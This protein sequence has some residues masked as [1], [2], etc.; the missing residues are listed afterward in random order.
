MGGHVPLSTPPG[1][2]PVLTVMPNGQ[3]VPP[4]LTPMKDATPGLHGVGTLTLLRLTPQ[5]S[6]SLAA[7]PSQDQEENMDSE[8]QGGPESQQ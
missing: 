2:S 3:L 6:A 5:P 7:P 8:P 4:M 1:P